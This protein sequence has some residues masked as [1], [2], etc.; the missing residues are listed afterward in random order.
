MNPAKYLN[1]TFTSAH[2]PGRAARRTTG[3]AGAR[4]RGDGYDAQRIAAAEAKRAR[5]RERNLRNAS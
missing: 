5:R 4:P 2:H 1:H 3:Y